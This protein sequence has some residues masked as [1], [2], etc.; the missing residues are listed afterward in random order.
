MRVGKLTEILPDEH[1]ANAH[2]P[3]GRGAVEASLRKR[4]FFRPMA[5]AG[6]GVAQPVMKAGNLTQEV[7]VDI[8]M[9]EAII[10]ESDGRRPIVHVR[11]DLEP[12]SPEARTLAI[13]DNR[14]AELSLSWD[15]SQIAQELEAGLDL[16]GMFYPEELSAILESAADG[17]VPDFQP[18]GEDEQGR[19][20]QKAP[21]VCPKCG[22]EFIPK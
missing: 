2:T 21:V 19:L 3:R 9:D 17:L 13:E 12:D 5:A 15:A 18:V 7:A 1:N 22:H 16:S 14:S 11:T 8:G 10:I 6:K 20:D 4:G